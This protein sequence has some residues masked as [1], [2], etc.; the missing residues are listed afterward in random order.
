ML[1]V[2]LN[3]W[4]SQFPSPVAFPC[5]PRHRSTPGHR[6]PKRFVNSRP[7]ENCK[8]R[9]P[10]KNQTGQQEAT[11]PAVRKLIPR[12]GEKPASACLRW[13]KVRFSDKHKEPWN[14]IYLNPLSLTA[15]PLVVQEYDRPLISDSGSFPRNTV[16]ANC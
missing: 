3:A 16:C 15:R 10:R 11:Y 9:M 6:P 4:K 12:R 13:P 14:Y 5:R 7:D 8:R 1:N 2:Q